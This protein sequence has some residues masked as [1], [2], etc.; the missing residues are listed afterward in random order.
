L[1]LAIP[2][3]CLPVDPVVAERAEVE[4]HGWEVAWDGLEMAI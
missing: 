2:A 1:D 4:A 3:L